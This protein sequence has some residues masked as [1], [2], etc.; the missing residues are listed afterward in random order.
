MCF[1]ACSSLS[2]STKKDRRVIALTLIIS[3]NIA[4][5]RPEKLK[6]ANSHT[7]LGKYNLL[8]TDYNLKII[9]N[10]SPVVSLYSHRV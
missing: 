2:T 6:G 4:I 1:A 10:L 3:L 8:T 5:S 9:A 7:V